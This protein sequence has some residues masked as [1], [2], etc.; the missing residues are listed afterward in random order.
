MILD[1]HR[2][3]EAAFDAVQEATDAG[4]RATAQKALGV[5]L[6]G[7]SI[8]EEVA[9]YPALAASHE[10]GHAELAYQEQSAAKMELGLLERLDPMSQ[11][12]RDKLEHIRGAVMH[13]VY[14]EEGTW[15]LDLKQNLS[16]DEQT[17]LSARYEEEFSRYMNAGDSPVSVLHQP[18]M[19]DVALRAVEK[20]DPVR[21]W[22]RGRDCY[23]DVLLH[24]TH[25]ARIMR[26]WVPHGCGQS[27]S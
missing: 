24:P 17:K 16:L 2:Q 18:G 8:A 27:S 1:H 20:I 13:H 5:I 9:I 3:I 23:A 6:T 7:H 26:H 25:A 19:N 10:V 22:R 14:S 15:F 11:D 12:Y 21:A 4:T